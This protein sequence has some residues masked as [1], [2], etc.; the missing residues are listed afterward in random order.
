MCVYSVCSKFHLL[1]LFFSCYLV[2]WWLILSSYFFLTSGYFSILL[3]IPFKNNTYWNMIY[4]IC[5]IQF[6]GI[7]FQINT[8]IKITS[9]AA[10]W[11]LADGI[12]AWGLYLN[13]RTSDSLDICWLLGTIWHF[14]DTEMTFIMTPLANVAGSLSLS[15][16]CALPI[17]TT[18]LDLLPFFRK[19][20]VGPGRHL[21][22]YLLY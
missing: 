11:H 7:N 10:N 20:P 6:Q 21:R 2:S 5:I 9:E 3:L 4:Y 13:Y 8:G 14:R 17:S 18:L 1:R 22:L 15:K 12:S 19:P 16:G